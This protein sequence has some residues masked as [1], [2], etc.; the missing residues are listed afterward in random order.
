MLLMY[1]YV[2]L[3]MSTWY[4][5]HV[6]ESNNIWRIN[7]IHCITLVVLYGHWS[8]ICQ[9]FRNSRSLTNMYKPYDRH[10]RKTWLSWLLRGKCKGCR[11]QWPRGLRRRSSGAHPPRLWVRIPQGYGCLS[12]V[13]VVCCQVKVSATDWSLVQRSPTDCGASLCAIKKP[14]K[15]GG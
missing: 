8:F 15:R 5:K 4:S 12:V 6:E 14:W 9:L 7:N 13:S 2:L 11:S 3:E 10:H 1:N